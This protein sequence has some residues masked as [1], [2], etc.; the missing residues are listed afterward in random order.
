MGVDRNR[1]IQARASRI[2]D[3]VERLRF[4]RSSPLSIEAARRKRLTSLGVALLCWGALVPYPSPNSIAG[5]TALPA[6]AAVRG[7]DLTARVWPVESRDGYE[8]YSNGLRIET[9]FTVSGRPR[10]AFPVFR[11]SADGLEGVREQRWQRVPA[12]IVFHET[13]SHQATFEPSE[14]ARLTRIGRNLL[15]FVRRNHSYH[16]V[17]DRFGRVWRIVPESDVAFHA[18]RSV[19]ADAEGAYVNLNTSFLGVAVESAAGAP[20]TGAQLHGVRVLTEWLRY[21][22][23]IYSWNCVTHAQVSVNP[24][25]MRIG[26]H[27][28]WAVGFPFGPSGLP[29]NYQVSLA[30]VR[31]FGFRYDS[32][33]VKAAGGHVWPGIERAEEE[34]RQEAARSHIDETRLRQRLQERYRQILRSA[35]LRPREGDNR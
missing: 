27:S 9:G 22:Y 15:E 10:E 12:G 35:E 17:V 25:N 23:G 3:P 21:R 32:A 26:Y 14:A 31:A 13:E 8:L 33:L 1:L 24:D 2:L 7:P 28:D 18:G 20:P 11:P 29:D 30:S 6:P 4:L 16:Y 19:W 34:L 5:T